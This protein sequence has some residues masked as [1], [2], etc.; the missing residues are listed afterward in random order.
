M[1]KT[2]R[3][4][5]DVIFS[6]GSFIAVDT[7]DEFV[8]NYTVI[9]H[10]NEDLC[11]F[12]NSPFDSHNFL[13]C[14]NKRNRSFTDSFQSCCTVRWYHHL[15]NA[16]ILYWLQSSFILSLGTGWTNRNRCL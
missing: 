4:V 9:K 14:W 15:H 2:P 16:C 7:Y 12:L 10:R 5:T 11:T 1:H 8:I 6:A 3:T 13:S